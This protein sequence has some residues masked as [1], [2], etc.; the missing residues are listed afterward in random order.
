MNVEKCTIIILKWEIEQNA[1]INYGKWGQREE[2]KNE[3]QNECDNM[4]ENENVR[5]KPKG[6]VC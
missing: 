5:V 2:K 6:S 4:N 3:V 1:R